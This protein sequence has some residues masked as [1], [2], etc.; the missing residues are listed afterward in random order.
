MLNHNSNKLNPRGIVGL[1][2]LYTKPPTNLL[3]FP[4]QKMFSIF[5][6]VCTLYLLTTSSEL[7]IGQTVAISLFVRETATLLLVGRGSG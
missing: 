1:Q 4:K 7:K 2:S 3:A 5:S 6:A